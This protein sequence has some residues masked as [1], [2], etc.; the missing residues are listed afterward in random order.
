MSTGSPKP[1]LTVV[2]IDDSEVVRVGLRALL[3]TE[4]GLRVVAEAGDVAGGVE[5]CVRLHPT[6]ALLDIR[7]PDGS[8]LKA[9]REILKRAPGTRILML[10]SSA[11]DATVAGAIGAGAHGYLLKEIDGRGLVRAIREVADGRSVLDPVVTAGALHLLRAAGGRD[12]LDSLSPQERRIL[13]LIADGC[14]NKEV[15]AKL[16]L[17]EKTIRNCLGTI[18]EKLHVSRRAEAAVLFAQDPRG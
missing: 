14:T 12:P 11:D 18:Y 9:C 1:P 16:G 3:E 17:S 13:A 7:L 6:V 8:G 4:P 15:G 2:L 10:T 5:A